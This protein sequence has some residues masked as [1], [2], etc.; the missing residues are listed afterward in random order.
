MRDSP[1]YELARCP[2]CAGA[3]TRQ[4]ADHDAVRREVEALWE[5]HTRRLRPGTPPARL[6]DR[7][8]FSQHPPFRIVE[9]L[10]CGQ[11][12]RNPRE[13]EHVVEAAYAG[14]APD[15]AVLAALFDTQLASY[16]AQ[17]ARLT[18]IARRAGSGLEVGSYV[19]GFL[20]AARDRG[21]R[22]EGVDVNAAACAFVRRRGYSVTTGDIASVPGD[23]RFD[24]VA[25]W[26]CLDQLTDPR[27]TLVAARRILSPGGTLAVR[28]PNGGLYAA[29]RPWLDRGAVAAPARV[30]LAHNNLLGFP[31][32][33][34]FTVASL[35]RLLAA[36]G[37]R[38]V[39]AVGDTLVPIADEHTR[40]WAAIEER[41]LKGVMRVAARPAARA[42]PWFEL[43]ARPDEPR[44]A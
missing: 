20:A 36:T 3:D 27:G 22:F 7:V 11:V 12:Y 4:L 23:R 34:G 14:D 32:R 28:V 26:N 24:A 39:R 21:W 6:T 42:A 35:T 18:R 10:V 1:A 5:F 41:A 43:Y 31:Y 33:W 25:I 30:L 38:V 9:C 29:L 44:V 8:A 19:G 2:V 40:W 13:R 16:R 17:A 37:F 15:D